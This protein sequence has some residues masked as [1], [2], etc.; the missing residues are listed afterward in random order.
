MKNEFEVVKWYVDTIETEKNAKTKTIYLRQRNEG[1]TKI[2][3]S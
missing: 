2:S 3:Q 1:K